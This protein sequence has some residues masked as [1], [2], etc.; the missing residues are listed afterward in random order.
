MLSDIFRVGYSLCVELKWRAEKWRSKSWFAKNGLSLS[1]WDEEWLGVLGGLLI[2]KP[3]CYDNY[4]TTSSLYR[5]FSSIEDI[6]K[7][8]NVLNEIIAFD[9]LLYLMTIKFEAIADRAITYKNLILTLWARHYL[10]LSEGL[11][12]LSLDELKTFFDD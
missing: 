4:K 11:A 2:K 9:D 1:F 5:E 12:P 3:L 8:E 7:A 6:R 10:G